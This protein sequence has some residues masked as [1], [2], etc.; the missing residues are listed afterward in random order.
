MFILYSI[1]IPLSPP[2][3]C[4]LLFFGINVV[5]HYGTQAEFSGACLPL[6]TRD[7]RERKFPISLSGSLVRYQKNK[8]PTGANDSVGAS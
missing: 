5:L 3:L 1:S 2:C 8:S 6:S 4:L 7:V